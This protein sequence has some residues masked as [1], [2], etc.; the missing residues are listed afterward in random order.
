MYIGSQKILNEET[1]AGGYVKVTLE[2]LPIDNLPTAE[3]E[4]IYNEEILKLI[5]SE[6]PNLDATGLRT[7]RCEPLISDIVMILFKYNIQMADLEYTFIGVE[8]TIRQARL[9]KERK[10]YG[11]NEYKRTIIQLKDELLSE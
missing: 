6:E 7:I 3:E 1:L 8:E 2:A 11:N 10:V 9:R 4:V 5:K